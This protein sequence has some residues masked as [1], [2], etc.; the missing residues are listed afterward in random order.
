[1]QDIYGH[2]CILGNIYWLYWSLAAHEVVIDDDD[3][4]NND[5]ATISAD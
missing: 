1:V 4:D 2:T 3:D 5:E